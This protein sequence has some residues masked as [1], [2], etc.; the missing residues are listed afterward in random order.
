[1]PPLATSAVC[2][3]AAFRGG[4]AVEPL[5]EEE[6]EDGLGE[7]SRFTEKSFMLSGEP[8]SSPFP[9]ASPGGKCSP[10]KSLEVG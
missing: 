6:T 8:V 10:G 5:V 1:M 7:E 9:P 3:L 4:T 2:P